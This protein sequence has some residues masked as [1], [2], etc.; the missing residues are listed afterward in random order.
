MHNYNLKKMIEE[1]EFFILFLKC[2]FFLISLHIYMY[3]NNF[4]I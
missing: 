2:L 1:L 4:K 3:N